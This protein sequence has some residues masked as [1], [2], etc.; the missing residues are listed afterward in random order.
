MFYEGATKE[1]ELLVSNPVPLHFTVPV[2]VGGDV[3]FGDAISILSGAFE[4]WKALIGRICVLAGSDRE[5][6]A[7]RQML[8]L[9]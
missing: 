5:S 6:T 3:K 8:G 1:R 4:H 2:L 9:G 7:L